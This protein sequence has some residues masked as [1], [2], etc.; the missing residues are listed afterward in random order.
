MSLIEIIFLAIALGIDCLVVSFSQGLIFSKNRT[1]NSIKLAIV[2]GVFQ[3]GMPIFGYIGANSM[4]ENILPFSKWIVFWIFFILGVKFI[5][6]SFKPKKAEIQCLDF[7]CLM[8]LGIATSMDALVSGA[9]L[10]LLHANLAVSMFVIG[11]TSF[12]MS[13]IGF[14]S[15]NKVKKLNSIVLEIIGGLILILLAFKA[16]FIG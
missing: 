9:S 12:I 4:Y 6:E 5:L 1:I 16:L 7:N 8:C 11:I 2:M 10:R 13:L 3:G 15:G 14:W